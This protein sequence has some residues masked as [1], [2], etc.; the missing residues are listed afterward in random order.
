MYAVRARALYSVT[1]KVEQFIYQKEQL[2][3]LPYQPNR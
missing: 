2:A 3:H 1:V